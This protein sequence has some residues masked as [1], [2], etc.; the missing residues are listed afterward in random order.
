MTLSGN[1]DFHLISKKTPGFVGADLSSLTKEAAIVAIN[2]IFARL[3]PSPL[4]PPI[5]L[6]D[7][8]FASALTVDHDDGGGRSATRCRE[9]AAGEGSPGIVTEG[10]VTG[11]PFPRAVGSG[12]PPALLHDR[13]SA[14]PPK[15]ASDGDVESLPLPPAATAGASGKALL[16]AGNGKSEVVREDFMAGPL[17]AEQLAPL[18]VTMEDFLAAVK[19]VWIIGGFNSR[20]R[21]GTKRC[22]QGRGVFV[23]FCF[24]LS[25]FVSFLLVFPS[26]LYFLF[27]IVIVLC[28]FVSCFP[29][30]SWGVLCS[31]LYHTEYYITVPKHY[32]ICTVNAVY[33]LFIHQ[34][35]YK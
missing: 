32:N 28:L 30:L 18:S 27:H 8:A 23:L 17:S 13:W 6:S 29:L 4:S 33:T 15:N 2:R 31:I 20:C 5:S 11:P 16:L 24:V 21:T 35:Y 19:K 12:T 26:F 1:V 7:N 10:G 3:S 14:S 34:L 22:C 25:C 9:L